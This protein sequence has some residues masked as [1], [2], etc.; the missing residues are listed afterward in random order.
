MIISV[1][2]DTAVAG[3]HAY[4]ASKVPIRKAAI[5]GLRA[6]K[7]A[8]HTLVLTSPRANKALRID[9]NLDPLVRDGTIHIDKQTWSLHRAVHSRRYSAMLSAIKPIEALFD[10]VDD[11]EQGP[12]VV[13]L[14]INGGTAVNGA[15]MS[16]SPRK[17]WYELAI[18]YGQ[19]ATVGK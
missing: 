13:D 19:L 4:G 9:R 17:A 2:F 12:L 8:G 16:M 3:K 15:H 5:I 10:A 14:A 11:G 18:T 6:L 7:S 1:E